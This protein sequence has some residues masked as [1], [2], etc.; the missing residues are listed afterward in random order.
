MPKKTQPRR[1]ISTTIYVTFWPKNPS[2]LTPK[3][4]QFLREKSIYIVNCKY[5]RFFGTSVWEQK[6]N[7]SVLNKSTYGGKTQCFGSPVLARIHVHVRPNRRSLLFW[8]GRKLFEMNPPEPTLIHIFW[9][10]GSENLLKLKSF[11]QGFFDWIKIV[12]FLIVKL[13]AF[14]D[15]KITPKNNQFYYKKIHNF[16][17]IKKALVEWF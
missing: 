7:K 3:C 2:K 1:W 5:F 10:I 14:R 9:C 15:L 17:P 12:D 4:Q 13:I 8:I 6:K 11:N 16:D